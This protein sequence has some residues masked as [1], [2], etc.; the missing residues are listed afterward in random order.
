M[1]DLKNAD[2]ATRICTET[3]NGF[4]NLFQRF[5]LDH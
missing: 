4:S 5:E 1:I 2:L 3:F